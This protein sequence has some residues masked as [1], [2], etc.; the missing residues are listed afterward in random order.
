MLILITFEWSSSLCLNN[1]RV[2]NLFTTQVGH[3]LESFSLTQ[4][5]NL[6][7]RNVFCSPKSFQIH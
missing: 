2:R 3:L 6:P 4:S 5:C 7:P 1:F